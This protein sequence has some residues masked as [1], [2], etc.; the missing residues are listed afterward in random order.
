MEE[1]GKLNNKG[2]E[3][4]PALSCCIISRQKIYPIE[5]KIESQNLCLVILR[6]VS[7]FI[8]L[9]IN[10]MSKLNPVMGHCPRDGFLHRKYV[11]RKAYIFQQRP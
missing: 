7:E 8:S 9:F 3:L 1:L 2:R 10:V 4:I 11:L 6:P 5:I